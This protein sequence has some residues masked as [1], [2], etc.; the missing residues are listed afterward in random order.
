MRAE[1]SRRGLMS[2]ETLE[3]SLPSSLC[4][5]TAT[6]QQ[7]VNQEV[8]SSD[9]KSAGA[10]I[11]DSQSLALREIKCLLSKPPSLWYFGILL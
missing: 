10:L 3:S 8:G 5:V 11:L 4:E 2:L 7:C 6:K 1:S 9:T